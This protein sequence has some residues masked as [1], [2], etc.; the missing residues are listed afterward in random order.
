[1]NEYPNSIRNNM[2]NTTPYKRDDYNIQISSLPAPNRSY[3]LQKGVNFKTIII[4]SLIAAATIGGVAYNGYVQHQSMLEK[5]NVIETVSMPG[6]VTLN[7]TENPEYSYFEM[8]DGTHVGNYNGMD[9]RAMVENQI[10][11]AQSMGKQM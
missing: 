10:E 4:A 2:V 6:D 9:A 11:T 1:M 7:V 3:K 5:T 8:A